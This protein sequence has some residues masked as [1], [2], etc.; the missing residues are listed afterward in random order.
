MNALELIAPAK[1]TLKKIKKP[2]RVIGIDLGTTNSTVSE[3]VYDPASKSDISVRCIAVEQPTGNRS[4]WNPLVPS[5][6][7]IHDGQEIVGEGARLLRS[8]GHEAGLIEE[9]NV[10][11]SVKN[12]IGLRRTYNMAPA[13]YRS[14]AEV[15]GRILS[16]LK[17]A[18]MKDKAL[19]PART[20]VTVPASFQTAQRDDTLKAASLAKLTVRGGDL[21]DEPVAAF[22]A[23]LA[24]YGD[25]K[26]VELGESKNLLVFDFG[27][28]TCDVAIF[29]LSTDLAGNLMIASLAVS[30]YNRLGGG[31]IDQAILY[32]HLVPMILEQ[33]E[34][35]RNSLDFEIKKNVLEPAF[36]Q[37]AE[38][39]KI[40]L[41][42]QL[43]QAIEKD[44][45]INGLTET[46]HKKFTCRLPEGG[47]LTLDNPSLSLET[48]EELIAP[49][50][51]MEL[52][53]VRETEYFQTLS[54]FSPI[55]D[56]LFRSGLKSDQIDICL[57]VGGSCLIPHVPDAMSKMFPNTKILSFGNSDAMQT[58]VASGAALNAL[59]LAITERP[60]IQPVCQ[61]TIA[62]VTN[63]GPFD[64]VKRGSTLPWPPEGG[65]K[66]LTNLMLSE[67]SPNKAV[68]V[69]V[70]IVALEEMG[71]H[72]L[73]SELWD[74]PAPVKAGEKIRLEYRYDEN[75]V[76][77]VRAFHADRDDVK[78]LK[79]R[80]EHPLTN[81]SNPQVIKLR[82]EDIEEK[83]RT[84]IIQPQE[85]R[86]IVM[87]LA[88][89]CAEIR[90]Y[91][92]AIAKLTELL[93]QRNEPDAAIINRMAMYCGYMGDIERE[94]RFYTEASAADPT[95][96]APWFNLALSLR[97]QKRL[98]E[99]KNSVDM[100][101]G[102]EN[103]S[104]PYYVLQAQ[105]VR[106]M[107]KD[108]ATKEFLD[109]AWKRFPKVTDQTDWDLG[110]YI[111]ASEMREDKEA[112]DLARQ[113]RSRRKTG[114]VLSRNE[115]QGSLPILAA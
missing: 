37:I 24:N 92:K 84:G 60:I 41:C 18:A 46:C 47:T 79:E 49:F 50:L 6:V 95:M 29:R 16:F 59:S 75:Q 21:L 114:T 109:I 74:I 62:L 111:T 40:G 115:G 83:L 9:S 81:I 108:F 8:K 11:A 44:D 32:E 7:A 105:V 66:E 73:M 13:G 82:I 104:A 65:Y 56:A 5:I 98:E 80:R 3:I 88:E 102:L 23:Y 54:I 27:G 52:L 101:I 100:A 19:E 25:K 86:S 94:Q 69:R 64:L 96:S 31:D 48:F 35:E 20:T 113:E 1:E 51:D 55:Q 53:F 78:P 97:K 45:Y 85:R 110:W 87:D 90:Q 91:E 10:F 89:D 63:N 70:E 38:Q 39:L 72:I 106:D 26:L 76:L 58:A 57:M 12:H 42:D 99:A 43:I 77:D 67:S 17:G 103:D 22:I 30:R 93:R 34:L 68:T 14:A 2:I 4:H 28:G 61:E 15:S 112:G 33:N 36:I 107:G 71:Q